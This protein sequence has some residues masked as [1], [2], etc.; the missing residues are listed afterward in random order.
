M[1]RPRQV[2][3]EAKL[4]GAGCRMSRT[5]GRFGGQP[6]G[7][8]T[9]RPSQI[10]T[11]MIA[12]KSQTHQGGDDCGSTQRGLRRGHRVRLNRCRVFV[13][14]ETEVLFVLQDT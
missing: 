2:D 10:E 6:G 4:R 9:T 5:C 11:W 12:R 13:H 8:E 7:A 1:S 3:Q 14:R